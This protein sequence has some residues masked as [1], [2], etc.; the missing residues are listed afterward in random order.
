MTS[1]ISVYNILNQKAQEQQSNF[2]N[3]ASFIKEAQNQIVSHILTLL[4][5]ISTIFYTDRT[6]KIFKNS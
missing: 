2:S 3:Y 6:S 1:D 5:F 4:N